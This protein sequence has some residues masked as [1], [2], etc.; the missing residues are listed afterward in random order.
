MQ[1]VLTDVAV[2]VE[3]ATW[4]ALRTAA[5]FDA[6]ESAVT[7]EEKSTEAAFSRLITAVAKMMITKQR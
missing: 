1:H 3:A 7:D 4:L 6:A 5:T 2:E